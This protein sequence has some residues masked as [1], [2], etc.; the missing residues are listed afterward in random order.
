[1][2][3]VYPVKYVELKTGRGE[4]WVG[5]GEVTLLGAGVGVGVAG[6]GGGGQASIRSNH[7]RPASLPTK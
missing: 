4:G 1:M 5:D 3:L 7:K 2:S 6:G